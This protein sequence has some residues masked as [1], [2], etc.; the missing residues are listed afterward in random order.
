MTRSARR[1]PDGHIERDRPLTRPV[2]LVLGALSAFGPLSMDLY[3]P[4]LPSLADDLGTTEAVAQLTMTA[5]MIGLALG[6]LLL[7]P[8]SDRFGRRVPLLLGVGT[9]AVASLL[10]VL[11]TDIG[12]LIALRLIQGLAGGAGIVVARAVVRDLC[13]TESAARVFSLLVLV[14]G[15]APVL[16]PVL[17]AQVLRFTEW[18]GTFVTLGLVGCALLMAAVWGV[19]ESLPPE[20]RARA[21]VAEGRRQVATVL[22][23]RGFVAHTAVLALGSTLLFCYIAMSPFVLQHEYGLSAQL[24]SVVFAANAVG[25]V[26]CGSLSA[27]L[28]QR[29]GP[30]ATLTAGL[31]T[32]AVAAVA[33]ALATALGAGLAVVLP[34][35]LAAVSTVSLVQPT[36]TALALTHH[37]SRAGAASGLVGLAQFGVGGAVAPLV[38]LAG[39]TAV[40][41]TVAMAVSVIVALAVHQTV[42][43]TH[44]APA[45]PHRGDPSARAMHSPPDPA[46]AGREQ[47]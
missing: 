11:A 14:S 12:V 1:A 33:L 34:L 43:R 45:V 24:F 42:R 13:D 37:A 19:R 41:M 16:A 22:R 28:V 46:S 21:G 44:R 8:V 47:R 39:T 18:R 5:C 25:L 40:V 30:A 6:Q 20:R 38:S 31:V 32:G 2:L 35:L 26:L 15:A 27:R 36:S 9:F 23:D 3:L 29:I 10:C 7:G 4:A 17:G